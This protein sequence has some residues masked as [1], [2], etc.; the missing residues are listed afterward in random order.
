MWRVIS[1][2][3]VSYS[4]P[5]IH[6]PKDVVISRSSGHLLTRI[7]QQPSEIRVQQHG[8]PNHLLVQ[9][10]AQTAEY[11][12]RELYQ[13]VNEPVA[14]DKHELL[15]R[16]EN[17]RRL[18]RVGREQAGTQAIL[19]H[20]ANVANDAGDQLLQRGDALISRMNNAV[21]IGCH[22]TDLLRKLREPRRTRY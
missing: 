3:N 16:Q 10:Q 12:R 1:A 2:P 17:L 7:E 19:A 8:R 11:R 4:G 21:K 14:G 5:G 20:K 6:I 13:R 9:E 15:R 18:D 22:E